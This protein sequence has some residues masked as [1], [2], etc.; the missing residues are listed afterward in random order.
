[1]IQ[2]FKVKIQHSF[3]YKKMNLNILFGQQQ[4]FCLDLSKVTFC[5]WH[6]AMFNS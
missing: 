1:M 5:H 6:I 2:S 4:P 3:F